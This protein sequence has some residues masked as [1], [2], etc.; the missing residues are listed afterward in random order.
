MWRFLVKRFYSDSKCNKLTKKCK[1]VTLSNLFQ[2]NFRWII[3]CNH[4]PIVFTFFSIP[5]QVTRVLVVHNKIEKKCCVFNLE[6]MLI[7]FCYLFTPT[8]IKL[9]YCSV[10]S[11]YLSFNHLLLL[12][13][14]SNDVAVSTSPVEQ[15]IA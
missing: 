15:S 10:I 7:Y 13:L 11:N 5:Q 14:Y 12:W 4:P 6:Q 1:K 9:E 2:R 8:A 3:W